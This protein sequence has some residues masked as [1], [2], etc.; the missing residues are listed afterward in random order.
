M[1]ENV[2]YQHT[3][4]KRFYCRDPKK[5]VKEKRLSS[6]VEDWEW[7]QNILHQSYV[8]D[9][10]KI[11]KNIVNQHELSNRIQEPSSE[12]VQKLEHFVKGLFKNSSHE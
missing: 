2:A 4:K 7:P 5:L 3:L 12:N 6:P 11:F 9:W 1:N 8:N 10:C